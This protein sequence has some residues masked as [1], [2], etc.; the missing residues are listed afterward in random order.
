MPRWVDPLPALKQRAADEINILLAG[1]TQEYAA[2][3]LEASQARISELRHGKLEAFSLDRLVTYLSRLGRVVELATS[4]R[5]GISVHPHR[6]PR[7][8]ALNAS[9]QSKKRKKPEAIPSR[10]GR[11]SSASINGS[12]DSADFAEDELSR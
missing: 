3:F 4:K 2:A 5:E 6:D 12:N 9:K 1:W 10:P 7:L 11:V 8:A